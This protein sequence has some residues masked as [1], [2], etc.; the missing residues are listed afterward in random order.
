LLENTGY[1]SG[2]KIRAITALDRGSRNFESIGSCLIFIVLKLAACMPESSRLPELIV[3]C[4]A[5]IN[6]K[7]R[8][9]LYFFMGVDLGVGI[10]LKTI[11]HST[12]GMN[13][14]NGF[15]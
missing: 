2:T 7:K 10:Q 3:G 11:K 6:I 1:I 15:P 5:S 14:T 13:C 12:G 9:G 4:T 8:K